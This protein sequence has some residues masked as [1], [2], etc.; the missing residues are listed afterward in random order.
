MKRPACV[1]SRHSAQAGVGFPASL[2][3]ATR[4]DGEDEE[5]GNAHQREERD[6][7][8][9]L[10]LHFRLLAAKAME[11]KRAARKATMR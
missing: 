8:S 3:S 6:P 2:S 4:P 5:H 7:L 10:A 11:P 1:R 9:Q